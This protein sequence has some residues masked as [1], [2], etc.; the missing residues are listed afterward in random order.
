MRYSNA[1]RRA[2]REGC[3]RAARSHT[4]RERYSQVVSVLVSL[5]RTNVLTPEIQGREIV[6]ALKHIAPLKSPQSVEG[7]A[8]RSVLARTP[9]AIEMYFRR[10]REWLTERIEFAQT[11]APSP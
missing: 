8:I 1:H 5:G 10:H 4:A 2:I 9:A 11:K 7:T 6:R 3:L